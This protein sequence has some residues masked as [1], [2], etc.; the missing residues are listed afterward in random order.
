M[1]S[2]FLAPLVS[3]AAAVAL[4]VAF[5]PQL[6]GLSRTWPW[7]GIVALRGSALVLACVLL[8]I[9]TFLGTTGRPVRTLTRPI[10]FWLIVFIAASGWMLFDRGLGLTNDA[11]DA[12]IS[13]PGSVTVLAW[14]TMGDKPA[15][16]AIA[17]QAV[18]HQATV[19]VLSETSAETAH[20]VA[21]IM[22]QAGMTVAEHA[23]AF[24]SDYI[25][26]STVV[27]IATSLGEYRI[28][29]AVGNTAIS[30][31]IIAVP[32]SG[33]GPT[34]VAAHAVSPNALSMGLWRADLTWLQTACQRENVIL[35]G[36]LN[37][38]IDNLSGLTTPGLEGVHLGSCV[39]AALTTKNAGV[40]TWPA[41][42]PAWLGAPIDHIM[43]S[44]S[45]RA[46][47]FRVLTEVDT[48]SGDHR[49]IVA[50]L[51]ATDDIPVTVAD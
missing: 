40:G 44:S 16:L 7:A 15:A 43:A 48:A 11:V 29:D 37:A 5:W 45:W 47:E 1:F 26:H 39:D 49:P 28:D 51:V 33:D 3:L 12:E 8:L 32:V 14:N 17:E 25:A 9:L 21:L 50:T 24:D 2:R 46:S 41:W 30:P 19:V 38:T 10:G 13:G 23:V 4:G 42:A 35:A 22:G 6:V 31:S 27:L 34:I 36:D 18:E 20:N